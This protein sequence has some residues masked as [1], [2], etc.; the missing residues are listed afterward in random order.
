MLSNIAL[1]EPDQELEERSHRY[2]RWAD[3][4]VNLVKSERAVRWV[5]EGITDHLRN[6]L[7]LPVNV[8]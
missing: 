8:D 5:M 6:I 4:F 2:C 3:D 7:N 1:N